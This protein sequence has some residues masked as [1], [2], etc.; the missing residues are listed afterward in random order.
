MHSIEK[1][2][3]TYAILMVMFFVFAGFS[4]AANS[5]TCVGPAPC[6]GDGW[7]WDDCSGPVFGPSPECIPGWKPGPTVP[8]PADV[9]PAGPAEL[10]LGA[11]GC[12]PVRYSPFGLF[13]IAESV[14]P[15]GYPTMGWAGPCFGPMNTC[16]DIGN[17]AW[18]DLRLNALRIHRG[19]RFSE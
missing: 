3:Y 18:S 7:V 6:A 15:N 9:F 19:L 1:F 13:M 12:F 10:C 11:S 2:V 5:Q 8:P 14:L 16:P 17:Q 4:A